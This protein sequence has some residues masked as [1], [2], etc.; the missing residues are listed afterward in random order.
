MARSTGVILA[1]GGITVTNQ[2][3]FNNQPLDWRVPIA[4]GFAAIIF[5]GAETFIGPDIPH[6]VALVALAAVIFT[7]IDP[8][9][10]SPAESALAWWNKSK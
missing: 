5:S 4:T 3:V 9:T 7:R 1:I 2:V 6:A 10:P 8:N